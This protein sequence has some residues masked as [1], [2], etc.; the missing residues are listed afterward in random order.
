MRGPKQP[1]TRPRSSGTREEP[2]RSG[3]LLG[4]CN[5]ALLEGIGAAEARGVCGRV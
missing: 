3:S 4:G 5:S 2:T 1:I